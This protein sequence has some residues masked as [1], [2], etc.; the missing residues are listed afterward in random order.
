[1]PIEAVIFDMDGVIVDSEG[2]WLKARE[3]FAGALGKTWTDDDQRACMGRSTLEWAHV[4]QERLQVESMSVEGIIDAVIENVKKRY[5]AH[6]PV[7]PGAIEA[8]HHAA[9]HYRVG[10]ASGSATALIKYVTQQTGIDK[11]LQ[12]MVYGDDL[13]RGKPAPDIY[14]KAA[15]L[16][17]VAP[18]NCLGIED[19]GNGIR[20]LHAAGMKIIAAPSPDYPLSQEILAMATHIVQSLEEVTPELYKSLE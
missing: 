20:S 16:L 4:V 8:V 15:E 9:A 7:R 3:D 18:E 17:G 10:L 2:Y 5:D 6:M 14:F 13:E 1:M 11:V 12:V 19:S